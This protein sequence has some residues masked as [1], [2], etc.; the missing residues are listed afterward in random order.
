M[1][2]PDTTRPVKPEIAAQYIQK[3]HEFVKTARAKTLAEKSVG[4]P[5]SKF[6]H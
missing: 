4:P 6:F 1:D 3:K 5:A 2:K